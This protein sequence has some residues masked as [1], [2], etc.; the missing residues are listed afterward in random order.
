M[1]N[2]PVPNAHGHQARDM[3]LREIIPFAGLQA[4]AATIGLRGNYLLCGSTSLAHADS[5]SLNRF[6]QFHDDLQQLLDGT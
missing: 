2:P 5:R 4:Q 6:V 1:S 3:G